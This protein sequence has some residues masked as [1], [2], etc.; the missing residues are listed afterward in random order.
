MDVVARHHLVVAGRV[1][2]DEAERTLF[3]W[4]HRRDDHLLADEF[5]VLLPGGLDDAADLV[6]EDE[7]ERVSSVDRALI[8]R[9]VGVADTAARYAYGGLVRTRSRLDRSAFELTGGCQEEP[10]TA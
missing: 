6:P 10:D 9:N 4:D 8:E 7:R 1:S 5:G 2:L 3:A